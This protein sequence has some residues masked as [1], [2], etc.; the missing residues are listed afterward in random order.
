MDALIL[1]CSTGGGHNAAGQALAEELKKRGHHVVMVDPYSL[2]GT[3]LGDK[4]GGVYVKLVQKMP[5]L[6]GF[7]YWIGG[8]YSRLIPFH[9]PV[10]WINKNMQEPMR[11]YLA[12]HP[13]DVIFMPHL[14]P[15]EILAGLRAEGDE[16]PMTVFIGTDYT[17]IPLTG[18]TD[19][20]YYV[21]PSPELAGKYM[22]SDIPLEKI[23]YFGIPTKQN[24]RKNT[25]RTE[26]AHC[27]GLDPRKHYLL[28]S[29]GS[30]GAGQIR[31]C[32]EKLQPYLAAHPEDVLIIICG[33]HARLY[34]HLRDEYGENPQ[35]LLLESTNHMPEY[36]KVADVLLS[37]PGG[38]TSTEAA[39][40]GVPLLHLAPIPG[41]ESSNVKFFSTRG[42]SLPAGH[43]MR[44]L[45][46][47]LERL[48]DPE[49]AAAMRDA[50]R[51][52]IN[53][54]AAED[55]CTFTEE[56]LMHRQNEAVMHRTGEAGYE[57][58]TQVAYERREAGETAS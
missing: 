1:S 47:L 18:E 39:V 11:R 14:F 8:V 35:M 27:L 52:N 45:P 9:S 50:Q 24:F 28:L 22:D 17:C 33:K 38:L 12:E 10:Y 30:I 26:A 53:P 6:F 44:H 29:G 23:R 21:I 15:A 31:R 48:Q 57:E 58:R 4:V 56:T 43:G 41:C 2:T 51:E 49:T 25:D 46:E 37:K 55:I 19:C 7:I 16:L 40:A 32:T 42:M 3:D 36:M 5:G 13:V 34:D 20:D 54:Q